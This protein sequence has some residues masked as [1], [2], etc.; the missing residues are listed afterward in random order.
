M[1]LVA[2]DIATG[3]LDSYPP[4]SNCAEEVVSALQHFVGP[5]E[6]VGFVAGDYAQ[7]YISARKQFG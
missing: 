4:G 3:W 5:T 7:E 2:R 6:K 1:A